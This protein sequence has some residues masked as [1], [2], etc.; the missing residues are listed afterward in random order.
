[1]PELPEVETMARDLRGRIAGKTIS[2]VWYDWPKS[3]HLERAGTKRQNLGHHPPSRNFFETEIA[4]LKILSVSRRAKNILIYL[5]R[6]K[7]L[8][9]HPKMTGHFLSGKWRIEHNRVIP[10]SE[11]A[12][13]EKINSYIHFL[14]WFADGSMIGFSDARKFGKILFGDR[15]AVF[16][17]RDLSLLGPEPLEKEFTIAVFR[18]II[19]RSRGKTK[20]FLLN[21]RKIA[22]IGNIYADESL[23]AARIHPERRIETLRDSEII[24]LYRAIRRILQDAVSRRGTSMADYRDTEGALGR[25]MPRIKVYGRKDEPCPRCKTP[26]RRI[27]IAAR[28]AH[29]C[30]RCQRAKNY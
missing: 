17:S 30:P 15:E 20:Q 25:Y 18:E 24:L 7:L 22:G 12:V 27:V 29:F 19:A 23:W 2:R 11:G 26:I 3:I 4:G 21:Q 9:I 6:N 14:L 8:L 16:S 10:L 28:S 1:M 5:S 13:R